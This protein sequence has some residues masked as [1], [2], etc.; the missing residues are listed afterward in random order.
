MLW[1]SWQFS[2]ALGC[3]VLYATPRGLH[4][5]VTFLYLILY[6][7]TIAESKNKYWMN[8]M[9]G[10]LS[11]AG[12][13]SGVTTTVSPNGACHYAASMVLVLASILTLI[14]VF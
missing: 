14:I 3:C 12:G 5:N 6:R 1:G 10:E 9:S 2:A 7:A 13:S 11:Y 8:V 4:I